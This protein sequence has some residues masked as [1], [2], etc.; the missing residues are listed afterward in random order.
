MSFRLPSADH[1]AR[2][3][4]GNM[5]TLA[6]QLNPANAAKLPAIWE[7]R[8]QALAQFAGDTTGA[9]ARVCIIVLRA[10]SDERWLVSFGPKGGWRKEWNFG[11]NR[12]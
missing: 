4:L 1:K 5:A 9:M 12:D 11:N 3:L 6:Q 10:D 2:A 8:K 7:A